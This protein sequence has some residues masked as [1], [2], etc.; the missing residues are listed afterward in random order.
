MRDQIQWEKKS[1]RIIMR[2]RELGNCLY[3]A[4]TMNI[5]PFVFC[6]F[7]CFLRQH[8]GNSFEEKL[9]KAQTRILL[10]KNTKYVVVPTWNLTVT[11]DMKTQLLEKLGPKIH[12]DSFRA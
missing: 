12:I 9:R 11:N 2:E 7:G 1:G 4:V 5:F 3:F 6:F 10:N 8:P